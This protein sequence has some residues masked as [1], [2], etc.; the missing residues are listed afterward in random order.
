MG[1]IKG[2]VVGVFEGLRRFDEHEQLQKVRRMFEE[3]EEKPKL[4]MEV[5][6]QF[7]ESFNEKTNLW[8]EHLLA[9]EEPILEEL[10]FCVKEGFCFK[11]H[12]YKHGEKITASDIHPVM[13]LIHQGQP[14][15]LVYHRM[16]KHHNVHRVLS[17]TDNTSLPYKDRDKTH[18]KYTVMNS[19]ALANARSAAKELHLLETR[20]SKQCEQKGLDGGQLLNAVLQKRQEEL[21]KIRHCPEYYASTKH[22]IRCSLQLDVL[23][24]DAFKPD[25]N[26]PNF[27][28]QTVEDAALCSVQAYNNK[29]RNHP[30]P[31]GMRNMGFLQRQDLGFDAFIYADPSQNRIYVSIK[32]SQKATQWL[33]QDLVLSS[34]GKLIT[35]N[36]DMLNFIADVL[37]QY[38]N[39]EIIFTGHSLGAAIA[40]YFGMHFKKTAIVFDNP[41]HVHKGD[42]SFVTSFA[43]LENLVNN[44]PPKNLGKGNIIPLIP[45]KNDTN[46]GFFRGIGKSILN[47]VLPEEITN[48][49]AHQMDYI[50]KSINRTKSAFLSQ[51]QQVTSCDFKYDLLIQFENVF[52]DTFKKQYHWFDEVQYESS[53]DNKSPFFD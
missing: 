45:P 50:L 48:L 5:V 25:Y 3:L 2:G 49:Y 37:S 26:N 44:V 20:F 41:G 52:S 6:E 13:E 31:K 12:N 34:S 33:L 16:G 39:A 8:L 22:R 4:A 53:L 10:K 11:S 28:W 36:N 9:A 47:A 19:L 7:K 21:S 14:I 43:V 18:I 38:K 15:H 51:N 46:P 42:E 23:L 27:V 17:Q 29:D 35:I 24:N 1:F 40:S 32:G 30:G